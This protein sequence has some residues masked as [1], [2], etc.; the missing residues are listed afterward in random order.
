MVVTQDI[1]ELQLDLTQERL[2]KVSGTDHKG[3]MR[4]RHLKITRKGGMTLV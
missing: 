1:G 2:I 4:T 3:A